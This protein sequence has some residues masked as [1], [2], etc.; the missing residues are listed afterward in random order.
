MTPYMFLFKF[1]EWTRLMW[2]KR[3]AMAWK[4]R[5][6]SVWRFQRENIINDNQCQSIS[7]GHSLW[8]KWALLLQLDSFNRY[9]FFFK[10]SN[11]RS[12][13]WYLSDKREEMPFNTLWNHTKQPLWFRVFFPLRLYVSVGLKADAYSSLTPSSD[14]I[15]NNRHCWNNLEHEK[16]HHIPSM[17]FPVGQINSWFMLG[18]FTLMAS[19]TYLARLEPI[20]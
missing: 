16:I 1:T 8:Y 5:Q 2:L 9:G 6:K 3:T 4:V 13:N 11:F 15:I 19:C 12:K 10:Q 20:L 17:L 18:Y 7:V 14:E